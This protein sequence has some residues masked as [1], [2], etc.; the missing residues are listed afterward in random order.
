MYYHRY[1]SMHHIDHQHQKFIFYLEYF[2]ISVACIF[3]FDITNVTCI[4]DFLMAVDFK[5]SHSRHA[6][7]HFFIYFWIQT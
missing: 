7:N 1:N 6:L 4:S 2:E 5:A 3:P